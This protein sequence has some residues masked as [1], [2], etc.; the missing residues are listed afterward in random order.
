MKLAED[1]Y[2][3]REVKK[4]HDPYKNKKILQEILN[5]QTFK[6]ITQL[7]KLSKEEDEN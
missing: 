1:S 4:A 2:E 7:Y 5:M 3:I 6:E